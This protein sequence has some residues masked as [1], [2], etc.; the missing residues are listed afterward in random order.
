MDFYD[1][2]EAIIVGFIL[3]FMIGPVFFMLIQTSIL[4]GFRAAFS[5]DLGVVLGDVFFLLIAYFGSR[6]V[7]MKIKDNP[8]LFIFGGLILVV[9]GLYSFFNQKQKAIIQDETLVV[10]PKTNY[11]NLFVKGF[12]LNFINIGVLGFW[13]GMIVVYGAKFQMNEPK[14]FWFF[15]VVLLSYLAT[16]I[17]KILLA[18][19]LRDKMKPT[20]VYKMK[21]TIG[22]ILIVFGLAL[23]SKGVFP[24]ENIHLKGV[25]KRIRNFE[26]S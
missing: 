20:T 26:N 14:I 16:D 12:L 21:R 3:A 10:I 5:F 6:F 25:E 15:S 22:I 19:K 4:K 24:K 11:L 7:L 9:Y 2:K 1:I 17:G 23:M 13:L 18:K 8:L